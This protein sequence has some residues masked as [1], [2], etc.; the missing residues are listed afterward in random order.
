MAQVALPSGTVSNDWTVTGAS[1][2]VALQSRD[3]D[4]TKIT[5]TTE[6]EI[7]IVNID[8]LTDPVSSTG[9]VITISAQ[10]TGSG[11]PERIQLKLFEGVTERAASGNLAI[12]RGSYNDFTYTLDATETNSITDYT[13]LRISINAIVLGSETLDVSYAELSIPDAPTGV[14]VLASPINTSAMI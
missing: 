12:T 10:A 1:A 8:S 9:H 11:G 14:S 7:C 5:E 3:D 4:T 6:G 13:T 2:H